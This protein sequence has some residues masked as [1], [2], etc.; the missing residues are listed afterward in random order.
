MPAEPWSDVLRM[1]GCL[2][3]TAVVAAP[4][5]LVRG[6]VATA[7]RWW[8]V[9]APAVL[10]LHAGVNALFLAVG[11]EV[12]EHPLA[13]NPPQPAI[14]VAAACIV[15]PLY[16]ELIFRG[17]VMLALRFVREWLTWVVLA[18]A[19]GAA[20]YYGG[21][22]PGVFAG[23][24]AMTW[25]G[26][27]YRRIDRGVYGSAALFAAVHS[28]VWPTPI[29]LFALGLGLGWVAVR[30]NG[31]LAPFLVHALFNTVSVLFVLS[32]GAK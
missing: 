21:V 19:V 13:T 22:G 3:I 28:A 7:V 30:T 14:F 2:A 27:R 23:V 16:E 24:V 18:A 26:A 17:V 32:G 9:V 4:L 29:P 8:A 25:V 20:I 1:V 6:A 11:A 10:L 12:R 15:V 31:I 5:L